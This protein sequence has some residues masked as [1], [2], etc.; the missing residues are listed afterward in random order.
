MAM[1]GRLRE[2][3]LAPPEISFADQ[4]ALSQKALGGF[5]GQRALVKFA[6]LEEQQLL[7]VIGVVEQDAALQNHRDAHDV[8]VFARRV[9]HQY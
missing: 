5:F 4:Q 1:K 2:S 7:N 6:L 9:A 3:P 8:A